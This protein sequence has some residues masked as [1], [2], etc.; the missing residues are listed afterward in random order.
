MVKCWYVVSAT[1]LNA[2]AK[3]RTNDA[4]GILH[5]YTQTCVDVTLMSSVHAHVYYISHNDV[6][7]FWASN[8]TET[9][10]YTQK[11]TNCCIYLCELLA[12]LAH[13]TKLI[14]P[15]GTTFRG[16]LI[17]GTRTFIIF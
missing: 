6:Q 15:P 13:E 16:G 8:T 12:H 7:L 14:S 4:P 10:R 9:E 2:S 11:R 1:F 5:T 3:T 17:T